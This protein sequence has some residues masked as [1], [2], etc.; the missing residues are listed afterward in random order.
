[1]AD[2]AT[3]CSTDTPPIEGSAI[4]AASISAAVASKESGRV[5]C[6]LNERVKEPQR[7]CTPSTLPPAPLELKVTLPAASA[8]SQMKRK[9]FI[10]P[11]IYGLEKERKKTT[12]KQP[13]KTTTTDQDRDKEKNTEGKKHTCSV[14]KD[15]GNV[16]ARIKEENDLT[17]SFSG[18]DGCGVAEGIWW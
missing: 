11:T 3:T 9:S 2:P 7:G 8:E 17:S 13:T 12:Q 6:P 18:A 16:S 10:K 14:H 5:T 1:M 15:R 4:N